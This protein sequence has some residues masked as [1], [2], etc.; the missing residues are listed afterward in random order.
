V[1]KTNLTFYEDRRPE[2]DHDRPKHVTCII[3][4]AENAIQVVLKVLIAFMS[5]QHNMM[6]NIRFLLSAA[7]WNDA[8]SAGNRIPTFRENVAP[9]S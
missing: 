5:T 2:D 1:L 9:S 3:S 8:A 6:L 7:F 4:A